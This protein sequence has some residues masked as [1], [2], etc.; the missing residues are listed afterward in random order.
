MTRLLAIVAIGLWVVSA[1]VFG[2]VYYKNR[3][4]MMAAERIQL[5]VTAKERK[6]VLKEMRMMLES[7]QGIL[8]A[9]ESRDMKALAEAAGSSGNVMLRALPPTLMAKVPKE[10]RMLARD[11]HILFTDIEREAKAG[12]DNT[13]IIGLLSEQLGVCT[14]CHDTYQ[15]RRNDE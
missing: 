15:F 2:V 14:A 12:A 10:F 9:L 1:A 4:Q 11:S 3:P 6:F 8:M 5:S 13:K 7:L